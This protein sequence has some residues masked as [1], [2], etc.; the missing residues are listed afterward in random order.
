MAATGEPAGGNLPIQKIGSND[1]IAISVYDAPEFI[2]TVR[3]SDD[4]FIRL[5]MLKERIHAEGLMPAELEESIGKALT[6]AGLLVDPFVT[7]TV[8]EYYSRPVSVMGAVHSPLTFQAA[9]RV[10]LLDALARA[11]GLTQEAGSEILLTRQTTIEDQSTALVQRI[12][13]KALID[14][15]DPEVN[16]P[17]T[18]G[19]QIRVPEA[20]KIFVIGNVK[21]PGAFVV[22]DGADA[23]VLKAL[24]VSEGLMPYAAKQAYIY[25]QEASGSKNEIPIELRKLMDRKSPDVP[26]MAN[27]ILYIPD[28]KGTRMRLEALEKL[29]I[30]GTGASTTL[31]YAGMMKP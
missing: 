25:R 24:A 18:G 5:P 19:E 3:V 20:G 11:G 1:L 8:A 9:G 12:S 23:T 10:N 28:A 29:L 30:I 15:A 6:Q 17:L 21:K 26:L 22:R 2:R 27:D 13:V 7:V 16:I 14:A 31:I 4:G